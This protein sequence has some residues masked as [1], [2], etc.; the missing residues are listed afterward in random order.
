MRAEETRTLADDMRDPDA[1]AVMLRI[2]ADYDRL[3]RLAEES[4]ERESRAL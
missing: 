3:G 2:A 4:A 1:K